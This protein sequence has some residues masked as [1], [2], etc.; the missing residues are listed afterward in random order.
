MHHRGGF[1][2]LF[3]CLAGGLS[4]GCASFVNQ[5]T[6]P[7]RIETALPDGSL[8]DGAECSLD[9]GTGSSKAYS[10]E[11]TQV[12]RSR[13]DLDI[14]CRLPGQP[15]ARGRLISRANVGLA[16]NFFFGGAV[17][18]AI[19]LGNASAYTYPT[20]VR[21]VFGQSLVFDRRLEEDGKP[22]MGLPPADRPS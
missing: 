22:L 13:L 9:D 15:D 10:G 20:W 12:T 4:S 1:A 2:I 11:T 18:A 17:G 7:M 19:D 16:G 6:H 14:V 3:A 21:L 8:R 5:A